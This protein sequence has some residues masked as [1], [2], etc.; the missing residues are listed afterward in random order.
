MGLIRFYCCPCL[1]YLYDDTKE[2]LTE[3][4]KAE[5]ERLIA[6]ARRKAELEAKN[7][8]TFVAKKFEK[9]VKGDKNMVAERIYKSEREREERV[10]SRR[11]RRDQR[12]TN[13]DLTELTV[14][15]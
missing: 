6:L 12:K 5:R 8:N 1:R 3:E 4:E 2:Q 13:R 7:P 15:F 10:V 11:E 14:H 9:K